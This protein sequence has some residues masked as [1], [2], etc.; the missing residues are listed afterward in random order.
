M[1]ASAPLPCIALI[2]AGGSGQ[3][4]G[5]ER[6]KQYLDL[7]GKPILRRTLDA[8]LSHPRIT[9]VQVV[10]DP[11]WR[12]QYDRAVA[13]L[14]LPEPATGGA[15]R[16]DSVRN[17][18]E[19][20]AALAAPPARVLIHDAARPL[21]DAATIGAVI[22]ALDETPGA[23]AA[24]P[25][26]DT[27]KRGAHGL[28]GATVDREGL[29]RA[30]TP[31]G[32]RFADILGAHRAA[33]GLALTDDA[34]VAEQAGLPVRLIPAT[35]DNFKVTTPDDLTRA[36]RVLMAGLGDIRTGTGFDVHRFTEGD[37]VMLCGLR[38]P[39]DQGLDGHS[40]ADVGLHALTDALLGALAAGDIG[41]HFPPSDPRWR[42]ADSARFLRHAADLVAERG[43]I[44]AH[45]DVTIICERPKVG[46]HRAAM[47][48]RIADILGIAEDRVSVKATTTERLGFTGRGEGIA[49]Q[50]VATIRLPG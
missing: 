25:V 11:T 17:G 5:A 37:F 7:L 13:G 2:V 48:A 45:A 36:A 10:I 21:T 41:S 46:P 19:A 30:Q 27:L 35:E 43:G 14:T 15:T 39:H 18:L 24:V 44:I 16:Q 38:V 1:P 6:P 26:A 49:A 12:A 9:G 8:F 4:F 33:A 31:Q 23:V 47:A 28:V 3:R 22:D 42:G 29:W 40:D 20:L 50:A 34:A 32:F